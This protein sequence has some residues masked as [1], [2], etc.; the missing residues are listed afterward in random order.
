M[1]I[2]SEHGSTFCDGSC[3]A[4]KAVYVCLDVLCM[5]QQPSYQAH[6]PPVFD[7]VSGFG[8]GKE[9]E[10]EVDAERSTTARPR[11]S[12]TT[13]RRTHFFSTT[14]ISARG[15]TTWRQTRRRRGPR[16]V[17]ERPVGIDACVCRA[18]WGAGPPRD[19]EQG[20][21]KAFLP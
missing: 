7:P 3:S 5:S 17:T 15:R 8:W 12:S 21:I 11:G 13:Q 14:T 4:M 2:I 1:I 6:P 20:H 16:R 19:G 18:L 9:S 10:P